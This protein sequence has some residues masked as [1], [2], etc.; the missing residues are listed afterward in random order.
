VNAAPATESACDTAEGNQ[1]SD[2][3]QEKQ[4]RLHPGA[5]AVVFLGVIFEAADEQRGAQHEQ[6]IGDDRAGE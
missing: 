1:Q 4:A 3:C 5:D 6:R 2:R